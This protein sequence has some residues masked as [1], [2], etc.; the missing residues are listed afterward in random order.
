MNEIHVMCV[1]VRL[2]KFQGSEPKQIREI[3]LAWQTHG[4]V[5]AGSC[6]QILFLNEFL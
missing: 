2:Y 4:L 1:Q 3:H 5:C 6:G